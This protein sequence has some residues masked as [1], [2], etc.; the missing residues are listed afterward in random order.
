MSLVVRA[1]LPPRPRAIDASEFASIIRGHE[2]FISLHVGVGREI[3]RY[4]V[5]WGMSCERR[6]L[7][8]IDFT[9]SDLSGSSFAGSDLTRAVFYCATL[10]RCD[11][12]KATLRWADLRGAI[13]A[14]AQ[15]GGA[16]LDE[17]DLR[18][19]VLVAGDGAHGIG[20][21]GETAGLRGSSL[22]RAQMDD[23]VALS[24]DFTNCSL[25]GAK[26]RNAN[27]RDANL[28]DANLAGADLHGA[29]LDGATLHRAILTGV[30]IS[31]LNLPPESLKGCVLD[32]T[33]AAFGAAAEI[34]E[35]LDAAQLWVEGGGARGARG[36][37]E[38]LD[39]RVVAGAFRD[40]ILGGLSA[41]RVNGVSV[42]FSRSQLQG[43]IF[44]GADLRHANF[45]GADLRGA[46][47]VGAKLAHAQLQGAD[48]G[49]LELPG[50][51]MLPT[52]FEDA[53]LDGTG[54]AP[55]T[56]TEAVPR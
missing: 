26:L 23:L 39:L 47:F 31:G 7:T 1:P 37:L 25:R 43:A 30:D 8:D 48:T 38:G 17:A 51:R 52:R 21:I 4:V 12:R 29:R 42:D 14:G 11:F 49:P 19:A 32:A 24:V 5:A 28:T 50:G 27:L 46:S 15:L 45:K 3:P 34:R 2:R 16:I 41:P 54:I 44:D 9:G 40:R 55:L 35:I 20:S 13:L 36:H 56:L 6:R 10:T 53:S 33:P 22:D 18:T